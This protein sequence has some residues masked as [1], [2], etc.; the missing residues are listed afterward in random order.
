[1]EQAALTQKAIELL[2]ELISIQSF[3]SEEDKTADAIENWFKAFDIPF[4]RHLNNVY[5]VN[6][7]FDESKPTL[8]LNSHHDTVK[9]N[10]AYTRDPFLPHIEDGKLYGLGSNDAGGALVSLIATFTH[11]YAEENLNHNILMVASMEEES[12]GPNSLRGLLPHLPKIDV[13]IVGEPTLLDLAIAEKGLV[14]FDA[15]IKGTPSHAAHPNDNNSI[16]NTIEVLEWFKN[17][18]FDRVSDALGPVKLTVTQING[19]SQHNVVP[20]QVD[21]VIDVRV[22]DKYTNSEIAE[23]LKKEAPCELKE[24]SLKLN[25]SAIDINHPLV[26]SGIALGR[27]TYGSPTLSDQAALSCQSLKLGPGDSTR[28]H[29]ADEYIYVH[30]IEEGIDLYINLLKGFLKQN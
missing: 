15:V 1:M 27:K 17:Y 7:H 14:V 3:S 21:L 11:Y 8:L 22:N 23:I 4:K 10:S 29:S 12:S 6:K 13:A 30:E 20:A 9:P 25:S 2:K 26:Q 18:K 24:R 19:G 5:A 16:Y 28:S